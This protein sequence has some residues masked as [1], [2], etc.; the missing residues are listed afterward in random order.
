MKYEN[1]GISVIHTLLF[2]ITFS[3]PAC[4]QHVN[5]STTV[6]L[7]V[8]TTITSY[9][10]SIKNDTDKTMVTIERFV[11]PL[12][13][14]YKYATDSNFTHKILYNNPSAYVRFSVARALEKV[15]E[16]LAKKGVGL[17]FYDAYRPYSVTKAM[18]K[19]VPDERYAANPAK[20]SGHNRGTA[21][22]VTLVQIRSGKELAMPTGFDDFSERAHHAFMNLPPDVLKNRELLKTTM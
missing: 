11:N 4:S 2:V 7:P 1:K 16:D 17:K 5:K 9:K 21:V 6:K 22:D 15:Q 19:V 8:I 14:D 12:F 20:G 10:K 13:T 18:W 3:Q